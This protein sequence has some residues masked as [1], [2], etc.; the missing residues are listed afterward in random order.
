M[1]LY[2]RSYYL[3]SDR[4]N[5]VVIV[6]HKP[7]TI[8]KEITSCKEKS[9]PHIIFSIIKTLSAHSLRSL[10][11]CGKP[12]SIASIPLEWLRNEWQQFVI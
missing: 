5:T 3:T 4:I 8:N 12:F 7:T 1:N 2:R 9:P 11:L 6:H 10:R